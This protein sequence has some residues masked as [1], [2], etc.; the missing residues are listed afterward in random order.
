MVVFFPEQF[1]A[2]EGRKLLQETCSSPL[3]LSPFFIMMKKR[4]VSF[5]VFFGGLKTGWG[6]KRRM[7]KKK[8]GGGGEL[9][10]QSVMTPLS[11]PPTPREWSQDTDSDGDGVHS[12]GCKTERVTFWKI[13]GKNVR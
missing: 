4:K 6:R 1:L 8:V 7:R 9:R 10:K 3:S 2:G 13:N 12:M 11:L 5:K